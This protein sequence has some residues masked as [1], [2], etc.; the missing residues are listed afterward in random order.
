MELQLELGPV[1]VEP[2]VVLRVPHHSAPRCAVRRLSLAGQPI[3][4]TTPWLRLS[5]L[6]PAENR[7]QLHIKPKHAA[8][9]RALQALQQAIGAA[10]GVE[11]LKLLQ[12]ARSLNAQWRQRYVLQPKVDRAKLRVD[13]RLTGA[14]T[15]LDQALLGACRATLCLRD[16]VQVGDAPAVGRLWLERVEVDT[17]PRAAVNLLARGLD[18]RGVRLPSH[19]CRA[20]YR[21][22]LQ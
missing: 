4:F 17:V 7:L 20:I 12:P 18:L 3:L 1:N 9:I 13:D 6:D 10:L 21:A 22:L 5:H 11:E 19:L 14:A 16:L 15:P 8:F 2:P